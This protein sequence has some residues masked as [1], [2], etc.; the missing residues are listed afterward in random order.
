MLYIIVQN[1]MKLFASVIYV[2]DGISWC[3]C[4]RQAYL[5]VEY[6]K[7]ATLGYPPALPTNMRIGWKGLPGTSTIAY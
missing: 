6:L 3:A 4:F 7:G 1:V 5:S 2:I